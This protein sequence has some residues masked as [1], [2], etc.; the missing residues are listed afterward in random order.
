MANGIFYHKADSQYDDL[1]DQYYHFPSQYLGRVNN[2]LGDRIIYYGPLS[3]NKSRYYTGVARV[4]RV[5][6]DTVK[7][8]HYYADV[9]EYIDFDEPIDYLKG[10]GWE[11]KLIQPDGSINAGRAVQA[12]RIITSEEFT[13]IIDAG[14][15]TPDEWPARDEASELAE[16]QDG[17]FEDTSATFE[18]PI[19]QQML[20]RPFR[21][22]KFRQHIRIAYNRTCAFTG[23][24]LINGKGRPEVEAAH[25]RPV[26]AGGSDS[27]RNGIALSATMHWMFDRG[28][29][30]IANDHRILQSRQLNYDVSH[31]LNRDMKAILPSNPRLKPHPDYLS[32]HRTHKFKA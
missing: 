6:E 24:R 3:G 27:V 25:I 16:S 4:V 18:R 26:E 22:A 32:W 29:L 31:I 8:G 9:D 15:S 7:S 12:V 17:F 2:C 10:G 19:I 1:P 21:E 28:L 14:M 11:R 13:A 30:S 5:R 20:N 23:L